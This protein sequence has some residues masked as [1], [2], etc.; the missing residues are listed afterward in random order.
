MPIVDMPLHELRKYNGRNPKPADHEE[1]WKRALNELDRTDPCVKLVPA[2][3]KTDIAECFDLYF[4]GVK[5][6][7]IHTK[8]LI[9]KENSE[10][11]PALIKFHGYAGNSGDWQS[12][13]G[14]A[15]SGFVVAAMDCRGQSGLS[16]DRGGVAGNTLQGHIIRGLD[17][18]DPDNLLF[19]QIFLD[20]AMLARIVMDMPFVDK[21]K[22]GVMG[23]SQGGGLTLACS[24]LVPGIRKLAPSCPFLCDYQRVW[25]MDLAKDAY[26]ELKQY[27][28]NFDPTHQ[29]EEEVFTKLGYIDLQ[30]L[31]DRIQGE[32][33]MVTGLMD[34]V[35][36][37]S[38]Q[39]AAYNKIKAQKEI[40][41]YPDFGHE[42]YPGFDDRVYQFM[43]ELKHNA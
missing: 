20:T 30:F 15:A 7:R 18:P 34:T 8:L 10:P 22:T 25:E 11:A 2:E 38:S 41:I 39:F 26:I 42:F 6:A 33:L 14:Y 19:R 29:R 43:M 27:F 24:S 28:R 31:V 1:Y 12:K 35:C 17:D 36:P 5:G 16:E 37:P 4:T 40:V 3:F 21:N 9:P 23:S 13:L 32:V